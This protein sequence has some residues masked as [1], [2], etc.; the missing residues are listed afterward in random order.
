MKMAV[1]S[2]ANVHMHHDKIGVSNRHKPDINYQ[3]IHHIQKYIQPVAINIK[4]SS[5]SKFLLTNLY[6]QIYFLIYCG[7]QNEVSIMKL[8]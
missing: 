2:P 8:I 7:L 6:F 3:S 1:A 5:K 4:F